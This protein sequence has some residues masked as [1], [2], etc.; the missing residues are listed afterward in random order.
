MP[1][2]GVDQVKSMVIDSVPRRSAVLYDENHS[3]SG[4]ELPDKH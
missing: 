3:D 1:P 2:N 4:S